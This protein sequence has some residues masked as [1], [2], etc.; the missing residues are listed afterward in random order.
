MFERP[1]VWRCLSPALA[2]VRDHLAEMDLL[3]RQLR[4]GGSHGRV[5]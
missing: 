5:R 2:H 3:K 4:A 1:P